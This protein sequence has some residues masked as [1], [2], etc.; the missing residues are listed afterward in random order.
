MR[1][2]LNLLCNLRGRVPVVADYVPRFAVDRCFGVVVKAPCT[3][4]VCEQL[5]SAIGYLPDA[6]AN[7]TGMR[8]SAELPLQS[9]A[10]DREV[11]GG[12]LR[13]ALTA[14]FL[15]CRPVQALAVAAI[16]RARRLRDTA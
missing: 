15:G 5:S 8:T 6:I 11:G 12:L 4:R 3:A 10:H 13:R 1:L 16:A 14:T 7:P 9:L 2:N